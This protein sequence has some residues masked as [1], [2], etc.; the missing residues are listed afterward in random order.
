MTGAVGTGLAAGIR[1]TGTSRLTSIGRED[2]MAE[3]PCRPASARLHGGGGG[4]FPPDAGNGLQT[5]SMDAAL[6]V[7]GHLNR[8]SDRRE[9]G[10]PAL[11]GVPGLFPFL[12]GGFW[13]QSQPSSKGS[14]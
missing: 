2:A 7:L 8:L 12:A 3:L 1:D 10:K 14:T 11:Y 6:G 5:S 13:L 4:A 9:A